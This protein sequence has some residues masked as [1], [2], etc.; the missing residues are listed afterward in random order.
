MLKPAQI[1]ALRAQAHSLK[2][3]ILLGQKG[4]TDAVANELDNALN[5]HELVK[6]K[7]AAAD[8]PAR[9]A[10]LD[11]ICVAAGAEVV[12]FIGGTATLFRRNHEKPVIKLSK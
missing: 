7:L 11:A 10:Q 12:Q 2:P 1:R 3:I 9:Q 6:I 5:H 8:K 4:F